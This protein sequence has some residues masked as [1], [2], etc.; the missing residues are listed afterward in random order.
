MCSLN[1]SPTPGGGAGCSWL[2]GVN[3]YL[4][5]NLSMICMREKTYALETSKGRFSGSFKSIRTMSPGYLYLCW[6]SL[7]SPKTEKC[8]GANNTMASL[9]PG[10]KLRSKIHRQIQHKEAIANVTSGRWYRICPIACKAFDRESLEY[11][12]CSTSSWR[13]IRVLV[14]EVRT[15]THRVDTL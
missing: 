9:C 5:Q 12:S 8:V 14:T 2:G 13:K 1:Q 6:C 7:G 15:Q 4:D 11:Q 3:C 10:R